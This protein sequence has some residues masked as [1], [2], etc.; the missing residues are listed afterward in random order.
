M[1][2]PV[3]RETAHSLIVEFFNRVISETGCPGPGGKNDD[4]KE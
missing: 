1:E 2:K 3:I 4:G